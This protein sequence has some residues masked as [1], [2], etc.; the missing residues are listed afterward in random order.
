MAN[1]A[2]APQE[3]W[4]QRLKRDRACFNKLGGTIAVI[5]A[6]VSILAA[7]NPHS[8]LGSLDHQSWGKLI[9]AIW[10]IAPPVF[11][12]VDWV[13]YLPGEQDRETAKHT[14]DLARNIWL[15]LLGVITFAFFGIP[16]LG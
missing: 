16:K 13:C 3:T 5:F 15:G 12:W 14:H 11:F 8:R 4:W 6:I 2:A 10:A 7:I 1:H 9:V